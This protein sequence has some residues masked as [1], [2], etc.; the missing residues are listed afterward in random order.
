MID[1]ILNLLFRCRHQRMSRPMT[2]S[3]KKPPQKGSDAG[4]YVVCLECGKQFDYD[5][6]KMR[7]GRPKRSLGA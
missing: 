2:P 5:L 1:T 6:A 7:V 3:S 4:T